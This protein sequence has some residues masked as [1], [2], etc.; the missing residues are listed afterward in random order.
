MQ[1]YKFNGPTNKY[2]IKDKVYMAIEESVTGGWKKF[3]DE[4]GDIHMITKTSDTPVQV[5]LSDFIHP[6]TMNEGIEDEHGMIN[7]KGLKKNK[8]SNQAEAIFKD[9]INFAQ[10][11]TPSPG[12]V[13][14]KQ[15]ENNDKASM[16]IDKI[17]KAALD[18]EGLFKETPRSL[19]IHHNDYIVVTHYYRER[20]QDNGLISIR[21]LKP[22]RSIDIKEGEVR[23]F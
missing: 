16:L 3:I 15:Q 23:V 6:I 5:S 11:H 19:L 10:S 14:R 18:Y 13:R 1:S 21:G 17:V 20:V 2:F 8:Y 4:E 7:M 9:A 12:D 22:F